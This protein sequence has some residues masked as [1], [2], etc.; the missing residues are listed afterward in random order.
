MKILIISL[1]RTG[2]SS[3]CNYLADK[4]SLECIPEP[5]NEL[6][7]LEK[8]KNYNWNDKESICVKTHINHNDINFYLEYVK[9]FDTIYLLSRKNLKECAESFAYA[10]YSRNF[11]DKYEWKSTPNLY[12]CIE[13]INEYNNKLIELSK[14]LNLDIIYYEDIFNISSDERLRCNIN[15]KWLI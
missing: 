15:K 8:Y 2:S 6:N 1:P 10:T 14:L 11:S 3:F 5:F 9:N 4:H 7:N 13:L 12:K